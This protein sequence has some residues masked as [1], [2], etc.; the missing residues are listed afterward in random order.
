MKILLINSRYYPYVIG[1]AELSV[2]YLAETLVQQG[3]DV[4]VACVIPGETA[5]NTIINGVK[6]YYCNLKNLYRPFKHTKNRKMLR[7]IWGLL[8]IYNPWITKQIYEIIKKEIPVIVNSNTLTGF[9]I[10]SWHLIKSKNIPIAHTLRDYYMICPSSTMYNHAKNCKKQ[11]YHC[12]LFSIGRLNL[13]N[14]IDSVV[15]VSKYILEK[16]ICL[17]YFQQTKIKKVINNINI[18]CSTK[19]TINKHINDT[20]RIGFIGRLQ[21]KKGINFLFNALEGL[22]HT[23][24]ELWLAGRQD[25]LPPQKR[26]CGVLAS[27]ISY[28]GFVRPE[29]FYPH[30]DVLIVPSLWNEPLPRTILEAYA[31]GIPVIGSNRGGIPEIIEETRTGFVYPATDTT[32]L[33]SRIEYF[34]N[35]PSLAFSMRKNCLKK[36][37]EFSPHVISQQYLNLYSEMLSQDIK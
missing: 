13:S 6:V 37:K 4:A 22:K 15:G 9:S 17:G 11:C 28:L 3:H 35:D 19:K 29:D 8:D 5:K 1:G 34:L 24:W 20:L 25:E 32:A 16:H 36:S 21:E 26:H 18:H 33:Q 31:F 23:K 7:L 27:K 30:I 14:K 2:Q 12:K 10:S